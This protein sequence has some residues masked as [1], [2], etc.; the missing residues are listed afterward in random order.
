MATRVELILEGLLIARSA[1]RTLRAYGIERE[2]A[3]A[4]I[5]RAEAEGR[6]PTVEEIRAELGDLD[7]TLDQLAEKIAQHRAD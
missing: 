6:E 2:R 7:G 1:L 3:L 5:E 4:I